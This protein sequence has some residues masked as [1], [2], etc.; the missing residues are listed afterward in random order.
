LL[1]LRPLYNLI[2]FSFVCNFIGQVFKVL[3]KWELVNIHRSRN[4]R[5]RNECEVLTAVIVKI[6]IFR[7][8]TPRNLLK[9]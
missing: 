3:V 5:K 8:I 7:E 6:F 9:L 1:V 4:L 2:N